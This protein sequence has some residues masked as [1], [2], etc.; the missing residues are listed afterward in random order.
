MRNIQSRKMSDF[1]FVTAHDIAV[2]LDVSRQRAHQIIKEQGFE[3]TNLGNM[4]L[5]DKQDYHLYLKRRKR[6]DL[7]KAAGR[8]EIKLIKH[9]RDDTT[10]NI[11]GAFATNWKGT[12]SCENGHIYK[13]E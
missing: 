4:L 7:A 11:C 3:T 13:G 5:I 6:R 12:V 9:S 1:P 10:C 2:D 8:L